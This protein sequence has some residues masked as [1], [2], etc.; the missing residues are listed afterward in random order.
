[1]EIERKF[2]VKEL[3][4]K[5]N[6]YKCKVIEQGYLCRKPTLRIR[7]SNEDFI[8][9]YKS[10]FGINDS[11]ERTA[12]VLNEVEVPLGREGYE[13]LK[14]K[15]DGYLIAKKRYLIPLT[16]ELTAELDIFEGRL[17]GLVVVE[18]EFKDEEAANS[19]CPPEWFG[20]D[21]S[22][23]SRYTNGN[24]STVEVYNF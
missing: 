10:D 20:E 9:T 14:E 13:H 4:E 6:Q 11:V 17:K 3:P 22:L 8:L 19:F 1:M 24:L 21:V 23:D 16:D 12:K 2:L 7:K 5:L 15:L 18:V